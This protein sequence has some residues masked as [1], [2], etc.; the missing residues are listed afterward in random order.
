MIVGHEKPMSSGD[1]M[2]GG[3]PKSD[4]LR[5]KDIKTEYGYSDHV[6]VC[7]LTTTKGTAW[8]TPLIGKKA[9]I[10]ILP[11]MYTVLSKFDQ[12]PIQDPYKSSGAKRDLTTRRFHV[13]SRTAMLR[14]LSI[15]LGQNNLLVQTAV[16]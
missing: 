1:R 15:C 8:L 12:P 4:M 16:R 2:V 9:K 13:F 3:L 5:G 10:T 7:E 6:F 11:D 14:Q